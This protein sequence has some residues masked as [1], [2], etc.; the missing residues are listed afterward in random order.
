[1]NISKKR[2][3]RSIASVGIFALGFSGGGHAF[4]AAIS[5]T[6]LVVFQQ[7]DSG[8]AATTAATD[9]NIVE[10][11]PAL[12]SQ[13]TPVQTFAISS[14]ASGALE[15]ASAASEGSLTLSNN[16]TLVTFAGYVGSV[17]TEADEAN[18]AAGAINAAGVYTEGATYTGLTTGNQTRSAFSPDGVNY[19]FGDKGGMYAGGGTT[20]VNANNVRSIK[21]FG[22]N[23]YVLQASSTTTN[24]LLSTA[25]PATPNG[26][27]PVTLTGLPGLV[28]NNNVV[29]FA[30]LS[31]GAQGAG[32]PDTLY[33]TSTQTGGT[34]GIL[35]FG[36]NG[37]TWV[38]E[39]NDTSLGLTV[40]GIT[41]AS[42]GAGGAN[43]FVTTSAAAGVLEEVTDSAG[44]L[45]TISDSTARVIYTAPSGTDLRGVAF[46]PVTTPEP[47]TAGLLLIGGGIMALRRRRRQPR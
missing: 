25:S 44:P 17:A 9:L 21:G 29:D 4:A 23:T 37:T 34:G 42:N 14:Q 27:S 38:A 32:V 13:T 5:P 16:N 30:L 36:F 35:K 15:T 2:L 12:T 11:N 20:P 24:I 43:L 6:D 7:G 19:Y 10:V 39:G 3:A 31:S 41:A 26:Q 46:A 45:S 28:N 1:M 22:S 18:R 40:S 47:G 8:D 33:V